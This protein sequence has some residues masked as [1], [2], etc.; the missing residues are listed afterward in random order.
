MEN[1]FKYLDRIERINF[2]I[3][4][5]ATGAPDEFSRKLKISKR[6]LFNDMNV[7]K[8]KGAEIKYNHTLETYYYEN[9]FNLEISIKY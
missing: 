9:D 4:H 8:S 2:L 6:Q 5:R 1:I 3:L 7:L